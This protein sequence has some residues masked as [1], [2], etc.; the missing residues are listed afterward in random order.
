MSRKKYEKI[1]DFI[2]DGLV[3]VAICHPEPGPEF[4]SGSTI[5]GSRNLLILLDA[6]PILNQVQHKVHDIFPVF[7]TFYEFI[8]YDFDVFTN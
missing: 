4:N 8:I 6:E 5:S 1:Y 2:Y 3:K 7:L